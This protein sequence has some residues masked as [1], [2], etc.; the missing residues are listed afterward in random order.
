METIQSF[1]DFI[2][3]IDAHLLDLVTKYNFWIYLIIA[4]II[5]SETAFVVT[6]FLPGDSL[7][8]AA[9]TLA[10]S[11]AINIALLMLIIFVSAILGDNINFNIGRYLGHRIVR[12]NYRALNKSHLDK[13][14]EFYGKHG[15]K[16]LIIAR[17]MPFLRSL[18]PFIAGMSEMEYRKFV[19]FCVLGNIIWT[20]F[21]CLLGYFIGQNQW[22]QQNFTLVILSITVLSTIPPFI[23]WLKHKFA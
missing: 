17:F 7:L 18:V 8:F 19:V 9:G 5:F 14:H 22:I 2:L 21:F 3:H 15:G 1:F 13:A 12:K 16:A 10:G 4:V 23:V 6:P 20:L 11:G